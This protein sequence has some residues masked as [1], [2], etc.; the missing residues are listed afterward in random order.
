MQV[1]PTTWSRRVWGRALLLAAAGMAVGGGRRLA[2]AGASVP[3]GGP[4]ERKARPEGGLVL[5]ERQVY[6]LRWG[7][8]VVGEAVLSIGE[9]LEP[10]PGGEEMGYPLSFRVSSSGIAERL[11]KVR[12]QITS[13]LPA[14][15]D[16][17]LG[18]HK[19][20]DEGGRMRDEVIIFDRAAGVARYTNF[21][22]PGG[23]VAVPE[24]IH[25][26]LS[27]LF[28]VRY[29]APLQTGERREILVTDGRRVVDVDVVVAAQETV[30]VPAGRFLA[31]RLEPETGDLRGVF[32][33]SRNSRLE[34]WLAD[35]AARTPIRLRGSV[36]VGTFAGELISQ[37]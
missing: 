1:R 18:Y 2:A 13:W 25:D 5:G 22:K 28:A 36:S 17:S 33:R 29:G 14:N 32:Q 23:E 20:Q 16:R 7:L 4:A 9:E 6:R 30:G 31:W 27:V 21:G 10:V 34:V 11:Y 35:D 19:V 12:T 24:M 8:F 15:A 37:G 26:P 3:P